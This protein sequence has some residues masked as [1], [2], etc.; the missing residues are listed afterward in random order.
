MK[1]VKLSYLVGNVD[2]N[3]VYFHM[4]CSLPKYSK[5]LLAVKL[6]TTQKSA[7]PPTNHPQ[8]SQTTLKPPKYQTNHQLISQKLH[9]Y[10]PEDTFL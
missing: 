6:E 10:F 8:T 3:N 5:L 7:K 4:I 1:I 2:E 9:S